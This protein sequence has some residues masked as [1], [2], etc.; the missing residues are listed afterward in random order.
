[1]CQHL[2]DGDPVVQNLLV[3]LLYGL[4]LAQRNDV[5]LRFAVTILLLP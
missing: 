5:E 4:T 2:M 3:S 1:M